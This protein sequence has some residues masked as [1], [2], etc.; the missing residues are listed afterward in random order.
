MRRFDT[1]APFSFC[2]DLL[3]SA[4]RLDHQSLHL[5]LQRSDLRHQLR[6]LIRSYAS[7]D[8]SPTDSTSSAQRAF[9]RNVDVGNVFILTQ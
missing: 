8:H 3:N 4:P 1:L 5:I 2:F 7:T 9:R 6:S